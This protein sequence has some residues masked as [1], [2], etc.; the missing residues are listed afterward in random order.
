M[1]E[2]DAVRIA[3]WQTH[4]QGTQP[5]PADVWDAAAVLLVALIDARARLA[6]AI[7][8]GRQIEYHLSVTQEAL[9]QARAQAAERHTR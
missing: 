3:S 1:S 4:Q 2:A 9:A 6:H 7:E 8:T 5:S